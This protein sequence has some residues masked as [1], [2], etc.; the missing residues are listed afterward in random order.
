MSLTEFLLNIRGGLRMPIL[1]RL[2]PVAHGGAQRA[3]ETDL[4][5]TVWQDVVDRGPYAVAHP[6]HM[7]RQGLW[8][9]LPKTMPNTRGWSEAQQFPLYA[10][11][12]LACGDARATQQL[13]HG[14]IVIAGLRVPTSTKANKGHGR[15]DDRFVVVNRQGRGTH[16]TAREFEGNTELAVRRS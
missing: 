5:E 1:D 2:T 11:Y 14:S 13:A 4:W 16:G 8:Q 9:L 7:M 12:V 10:C 15:Y 6:D 3:L